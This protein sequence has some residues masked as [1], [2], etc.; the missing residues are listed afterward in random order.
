MKNIAIRY[1]VQLQKLVRAIRKD[2][3]ATLL[4]IVRQYVPE[5]TVDSAP[6]ATSDG[7]SDAIVTALQ[8]LK[9][10]WENYR[11]A[12]HVA[13]DFV[14]SA[15][16]YNDRQF[17]RTT[18][19]N[20]FEGDAR[21]QDYLKAATYQNVQLIQSIPERYLAQVENIVIGNM[22]TGMRPGYIA[23]ALTQ[24]FG[25]EQ[26]RARFIARDQSAKVTGEMTKQRQLGAGFEYFKWRDSDDSR[27]RDR[28]R[29]IAEKVTAYG[30]GVY[31]WD[32]LP[33][34]NKGGGR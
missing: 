23:K 33:L 34:S 15:L 14:R 6:V 3:D 10:R 25:V 28:H 24:Q 29:Q 21:M 26:R 16:D 20:I 30:K 12:S 19:I 27:V 9:A 32:N 17:R 31:R 1:N 13:S 22:R 7:W 8:M 5:Y 18:G 2:V 11:E 4:P